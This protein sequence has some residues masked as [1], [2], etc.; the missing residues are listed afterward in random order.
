MK[1]TKTSEPNVSGGFHLI[2]MFTHASSFLTF[3]CYCRL[4][5]PCFM[6]KS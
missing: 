2:L 1:Q 4:I 3:T 6:S 5:M